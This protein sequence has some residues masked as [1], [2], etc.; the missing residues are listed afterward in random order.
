MN[1]NDVDVLNASP[2]KKGSRKLIKRKRQNGS[3]EMDRFGKWFS[4]DWALGYNPN[5]VNEDLKVR[6]TMKNHD[7]HQ[8]IIKCE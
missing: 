4:P 2:G 5:D 1:Q 7:C 8:Y 6:V 3:T